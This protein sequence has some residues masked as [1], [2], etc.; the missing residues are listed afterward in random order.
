ME[1]KWTTSLTSQDLKFLHGYR[2]LQYRKCAYGDMSCVLGQDPVAHP[3]WQAGP[4]LL[5]VISNCPV[6]WVRTQQEERDLHPTEMLLAQGFPAVP[7]YTP[8]G[9]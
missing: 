8:Y 4:Y 3:Q 2:N 9:F 7:E 5:T 1:S 6:L